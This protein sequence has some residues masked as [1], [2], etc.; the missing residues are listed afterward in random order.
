VSQV[1]GTGSGLCPMAFCVG[2]VVCFTDE[3]SFVAVFALAI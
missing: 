2:G 1:D 3:W